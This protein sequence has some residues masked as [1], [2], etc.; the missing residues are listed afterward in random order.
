MCIVPEAVWF[1][2]CIAPEAVCGGR[3]AD[4]VLTGIFLKW[5]IAPEAVWFG[6]RQVTWMQERFVDIPVRL[7][8]A[9][10]ATERQIAPFFSQHP[11]DCAPKAGQWGRVPVGIQR[12][13]V[14]VGVDSRRVRFAS[15]LP[16]GWQYS[17]NP[18]LG[19]SRRK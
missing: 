9:L 5:W 10:D 13:R 16:P 6:V 14:P 18:D 11:V 7:M 2:V 17:R 8:S 1:D 12:G 3:P 15:K 19:S 4:T